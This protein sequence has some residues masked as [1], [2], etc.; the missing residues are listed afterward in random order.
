M[1]RVSE[2]A[3]QMISRAARDVEETD[4]FCEYLVSDGGVEDCCDACMVFCVSFPMREHSN[5]L[6]TFQ[7]YCLGDLLRFFNSWF[8][9]FEG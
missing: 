2:W 5:E 1:Y 6:N 9:C 3:S 7:V 8:W 4:A